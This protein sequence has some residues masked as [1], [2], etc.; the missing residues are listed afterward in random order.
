M[1]FCSDGKFLLTCLGLCAASGQFSCPFCVV[2]HT[3]WNDIYEGNKSVSGYERVSMDDMN[4]WKGSACL[5]HEDGCG[6]KKHGKDREN[7]LQGLFD[8]E[9]I[10]IDELHLFLRLWDVMLDILLSYV[11]LNDKE[12]LLERVA[13]ML[14]VTFGLMKGEDKKG[15]QLW[16]PLTGD[17]AKQL[18][19]GLVNKKELMQSLFEKEDEYEFNM[20][21]SLFSCFN[22]MIDYLRDER[23]VLKNVNEYNNCVEQ[24]MSLL[25][26]GYGNVIGRL[27][28]LHIMYCH[29]PM[30]LERMGGSIYFASCSEQERLNGQHTHQ[31]LSCTQKHQSSIQLMKRMRTQV[32]FTQHPESKLQHNKQQK[33]RKKKTVEEREKAVGSKTTQTLND[34]TKPIQK[35]KR[36]KKVRKMTLYKE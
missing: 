16:S 15:F 30:I 3:H 36:K 25:G 13:G 21:F 10:I 27:W 29:L 19:E 17:K 4:M 18:L 28:Y 33:K 24:F 22:D 23:S 12:E 34:Y 2:P 14:G 32:H 5:L 35:K 20:T 9:H 26:E 11:E 6:K 7:L 1:F 31:L 8:F